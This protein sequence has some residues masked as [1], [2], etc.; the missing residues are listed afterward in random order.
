[1]TSGDLFGVLCRQNISNYDG[2]PSRDA[3]D[4]FTCYSVAWKIVFGPA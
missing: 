2:A 1:V 4:T 3:L